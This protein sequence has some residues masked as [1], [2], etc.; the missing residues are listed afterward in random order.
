[1][2]SDHLLISDASTRNLDRPD[3]NRRKPDRVLQTPEQQRK[4]HAG[5]DLNPSPTTKVGSTTSNPTS[6]FLPTRPPTQTKTGE[7]DEQKWRA[8]QLNVSSPGLRHCGEAADNV[9]P[10]KRGFLSY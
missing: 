10:G 9:Q 8:L 7:E 3:L 4:S 2:T 5:T 1:M 6:S